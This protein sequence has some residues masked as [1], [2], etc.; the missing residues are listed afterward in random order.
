MHFYKVVYYYLLKIFL[1]YL[2]VLTKMGIFILFYHFVLHEPYS[3]FSIGYTN[4]QSNHISIDISLPGCFMNGYPISNH[5]LQLQSRQSVHI[6][7]IVDTR[8][9]SLFMHLF[10][11]VITLKACGMRVHQV[12]LENKQFKKKI[13]TTLILSSLAFSPRHFANNFLFFFV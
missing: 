2:S 10:T 12:Q 4:N 13:V 8:I 3:S 1:S 9:S 11:G 7:L 5:F 6:V